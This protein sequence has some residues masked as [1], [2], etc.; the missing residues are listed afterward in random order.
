M[1]HH[2][3]LIEIGTEE[4]PPRLLQQLSKSL[5]EEIGRQLSENNL[6]HEKISLFATPRRLAVIVHALQQKQ[7]DYETIRKGPYLSAAFDNH[8]KP[9]PA[10][11]GFAKSCGVTIEELKTSSSDKGEILIYHEKIV[12]KTVQQLLPELLQHALNHLPIT[13]PMRWANH[14]TSFIRPVH[15]V[16]LLYGHEKIDATI[17]GQKASNITYGHRFHSPDPI[18]ITSPDEYEK[19]LAQQKVVA[20][21][22][23]RRD[24]IQQKVENL[25]KQHNVTVVIE[26]K[27]LDEVTALVEWPV[28]LLANFDKEFLSVPP[29]ALIA[30]MHEHQKCFYVVDQQQKLLPHFITVSNIESHDPNIVIEGN[31]RVMRAR[32][33][34]AA[35]F[36]K[37]DLKQPLEHHLPTLKN[38]TF[39]A[40]L[41]SL[42]DKSVRLSNLSHHIANLIENNPEDASRAGLLSQCDLLSDM[43][44]EF[45]ELQGIM[46]YYYA[47]HDGEPND[48]AI[49]LKEQYLP[50]FAKDNLPTTLTG[51]AVALAARFDLLVGIFGINQIPTGEKDP[52]GLR[53]AAIGIVRI[54]IEKKL[55]L[56]LY[57]LI[58]KSIDTYGDTLINKE[59]FTQVHHFIIE[60]LRSHYA[61]QHISND[62]LNAV[63]VRQSKQLL[64]THRRIQAI[65]AFQQLDEA[66]ALAAANKRVSKL[67]EKEASSQ[68]TNGF[69]KSLIEVDAEKN[70]A[71]LIEIKRTIVLPLFKAGQYEAALSELATLRTP[72]DLFFDNVMVM[73][74]D[75]KVRKN[76]LAL[77]ANLRQLFLEVADI[78]LLNLS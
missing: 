13:K 47:V 17:L 75:E 18:V 7:D 48:V 77:L 2:D 44:G 69:N 59:V 73:V 56:D 26:P 6:H 72:I 70:L 24:A 67:L 36:Y 9:T 57:S 12:G 39:Q 62:V 61:E 22:K 40:K 68:L 51:C 58:E 49:A 21:F 3:L 23:T 31:E 42:H 32:L 19:K 28:P 33:A 45:P 60:R 66:K 37:T 64:D 76:R 54:I 43:V 16:L 78:S 4:L 52:F 34:D 8:G 5:G 10:C 63:L 53:R 65:I 1:T 30:S 41:G 50:R 11:M 74:E 14:E 38:V 25:A 27:L 55:T 46:G 35:F 71:E 20:N 29:E 15:W